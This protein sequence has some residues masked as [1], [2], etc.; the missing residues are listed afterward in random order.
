[1]TGGQILR[2]KTGYLI[3][4]LIV[5]CCVLVYSFPSLSFLTRLPVHCL[6]YFFYTHKTQC[7]KR[8]K[9]KSVVFLMFFLH[10]LQEKEKDILQRHLQTFRLYRLTISL[11]TYRSIHLQLLSPRGC[12]PHSRFSYPELLEVTALHPNRNPELKRTS[13]NSDSDSDFNSESKQREWV[14]TN[15]SEIGVFLGV[16][17]LQGECKL[18]R[19]E[20]Y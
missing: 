9:K 7:L 16:L 4:S 20:N 13:S 18:P 2:L 10:L 19:T 15:G 8:M 17:R 12:I 1:M 3:T 11:F 6:F 5:Y 14:E